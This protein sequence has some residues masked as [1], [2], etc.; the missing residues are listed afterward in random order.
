MEPNSGL[1]VELHGNPLR[2]ISND[3]N[4]QVLGK[5]GANVSPVGLMEAVK[6]QKKQK[7]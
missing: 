6:L 5:D 7:A 2:N 3:C 1:R 4:F